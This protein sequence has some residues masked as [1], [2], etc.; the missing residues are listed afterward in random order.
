MWPASSRCARLGDDQ[1]WRESRSTKELRRPPVFLHLEG[2]R[3]VWRDAI[4]GAYLKREQKTQTASLPF[5]LIFFFPSQQAAPYLMFPFILLTCECVS[6]GNGI[7][8]GL[9]EKSQCIQN[10]SNEVQMMF[11]RIGINYKWEIGAICLRRSTS[12]V[13]LMARVQV[14]PNH[15]KRST[16]KDDEGESFVCN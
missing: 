1:P 6:M 9:S 2:F 16:A 14:L 5:F 10:L 4:V 7:L 12:H 11:C 15:S 13:S 3:S 8:M